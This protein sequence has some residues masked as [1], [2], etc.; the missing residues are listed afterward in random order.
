MLAKDGSPQAIRALAE[1]VVRSDDDRV[2][3]IAL[4]GVSRPMEQRCVDEVCAVWAATRNA[5][6]AALLVK[7]QWIAINPIEVKV[8][9]ALLTGYILGVVKSG[10]TIVP[11]LVAAC[12]DQDPK[13]PSVQEWSSAN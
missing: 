12:L 11:P 1:A 10:E 5:D 3:A 13:I 7:H 6:L 8:L 9:S 2:K 4:D